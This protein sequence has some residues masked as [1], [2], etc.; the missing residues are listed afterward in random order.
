MRKTC[1]REKRQEKP[2][3]N[4]NIVAAKVALT[5]THSSRKTGR[6]RVR[7][8]EGESRRGYVAIAMILI[9]RG[10]KCRI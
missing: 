4:Q 6:E 5:P 1:H 3:Q 2:N 7:E 9:A 8:G 10:H